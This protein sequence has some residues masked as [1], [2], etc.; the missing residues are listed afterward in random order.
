MSP[1]RQRRTR[2]LSHRMAP[3]VPRPASCQLSTR[4]LPDL[5]NAGP[6]RGCR[7][8]GTRRHVMPGAY[9]RFM[10]IYTSLEPVIRALPCQSGGL[11]AP[12]LPL[13]PA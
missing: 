6:A 3:P 4:L 9:N 5:P 8:A 2:A 12:L 10:S 13:H 1:A 11:R 7:G